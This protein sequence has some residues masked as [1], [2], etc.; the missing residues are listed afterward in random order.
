MVRV[1]FIHVAR[2]GSVEYFKHQRLAEYT[3]LSKVSSYFLWQSSVARPD[4]FLSHSRWEV[5][6]VDRRRHSM[7][8]MGR[9]FALDPKPSR[10]C[11]AILMATRSPFGLVQLGR[12]FRTTR[13]DVIYTSQQTIDLV[14][15]RCLGLL[16]QT[17]HIIHLSYPV[18]PWWNPLALRIVRH[19]KRLIAVSDFVRTTA[20]DSG[21]SPES[22]RTVHNPLDLVRFRQPR[23]PTY[24]HRQLGLSPDA[25]VVIAAAR[26]DPGKGVDTAIAAFG[27]LQA[28]RRNV[29]L[30]IC[31]RSFT[32]TGYDEQ[33][34]TLA[35][36]TGAAGRIIFAGFRDD[37]P[38]LLSGSDIFCLPTVNEAFGF[39]FIEAMSSGLPV[40]ACRS[41]GV[42]EIV[43][44]GVDGFLA[45][46]DDVDEVASYLRR[47]VDDRALRQRMGDAGRT[48]VRS[49]FDPQRI[50]AK[51]QQAVEEL[52]VTR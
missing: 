45:S 34:K 18:G 8:D 28:D 51:W 50:S 33:L 6:T 11:R 22:V 46:V 25:T 48:A 10:A 15:A 36:E 9:D 44:H 27:R 32:R 49:A 47:L 37:M 42:P 7:V 23:D 24:V 29:V 30:V 12:W 43:R 39:V 1:G 52:A 26:L 20:I 5:D 21:V 38:K 14:V 31:G 13:P 41:G 40:V 4:Q 2:D 17:P 19:S 35:E 3:P 16:T